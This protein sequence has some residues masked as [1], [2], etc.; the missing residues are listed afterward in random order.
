MARP[1]VYCS[2]R[3]NFTLR[4]NNSEENVN[5]FANFQ[6]E[7][8]QQYNNMS[9]DSSFFGNVDLVKNRGT[10][11]VGVRRLLIKWDHNAI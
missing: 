3:N 8:C 1:S 4:S 5:F 6:H 9:T 7:A 10:A 11:I 2:L